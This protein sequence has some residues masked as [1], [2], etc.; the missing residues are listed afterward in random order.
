MAKCDCPKPKRQMVRCPGCGRLQKTRKALGR[1]AI[2]IVRHAHGH[3]FGHDC[4]GSGQ[5]VS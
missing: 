5:K 3:A 4:T 1:D 2:V